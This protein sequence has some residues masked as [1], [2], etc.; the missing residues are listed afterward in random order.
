MWGKVALGVIMFCGVGILVTVVSAIWA[1]TYA[2]S[3]D[4]RYVVLTVFSALIPMFGTCA[5]AA[6]AFYFSQEG[7]AAAASR[8]LLL[9][10]ASVADVGIAVDQI[11]AMT[12]AIGDEPS[13]RFASVKA[14]LRRGVSRIPVWDK[15]GMV[16][17]V[18]HESMIYKYLAENP[19]ALTDRT[20]NDFL[21]FTVRDIS[22]RTVV[23][24]IAWASQDDTL[25]LARDKM[26]AK[27]D[28]RDVFVTADG[29]QYRP[30][31]RWITNSDIAAKAKL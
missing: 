1:G 20:L 30:V 22:M 15:S 3:L 9:R 14:M 18:I 10:K 4:N 16:R 12:V 17:Y 19:H 27:P 8:E 23:S 29:R 11:E 5:G 31:L 2:S 25:A 7:F 28:C 6:I 21:N 24:T 26:M 13:V